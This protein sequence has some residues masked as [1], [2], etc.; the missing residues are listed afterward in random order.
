LIIALFG[1]T[2][3]TVPVCTAGGHS[4]PGPALRR[5]I[6]DLGRQ[7]MADAGRKGGRALPWCGDAAM[8]VR[9]AG[10]DKKHRRNG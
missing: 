1:G 9:S 5:T 7:Q 8:P 4:V 6:P 2:M 10:P 3:V